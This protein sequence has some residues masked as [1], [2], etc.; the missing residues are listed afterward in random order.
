MRKGR[1]IEVAQARSLEEAGEQLVP[2]TLLM[3]AVLNM[4]EALVQASI[5]RLA[6]G[7]AS[8]YPA[9]VCCPL[10]MSST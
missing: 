4:S 1:V 3:T 2:L 6:T 5:P 7:A 9:S 10:R 8:M